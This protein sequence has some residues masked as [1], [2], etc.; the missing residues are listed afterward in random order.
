MTTVA[1]YFLNVVF[2]VLMFL[3][4]LQAQ[5]SESVDQDPVPTAVQKA[6]NKA[7]NQ[8]LQ[9]IPEKP[10]KELQSDA[11]VQSYNALIDQMDELYHQL[12]SGN[13]SKDGQVFFSEKMDV[14]R[15]ILKGIDQSLAVR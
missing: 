10:Q 2:V 3:S 7:F 13:E 1:S 6:F 14:T 5:S 9:D 8:F 12:P 11:F 4:P 15:A